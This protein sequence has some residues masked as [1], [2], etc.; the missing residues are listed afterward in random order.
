[1]ELRSSGS[2]L[3]AL[4]QKRYGALELWR[5]A[6]GVGTWRS[7]PQEVWRCVAGVLPPRG[8]ELQSSEV[9]CRRCLKRSMERWS[10]SVLLLLKFLA[11]VPHGSFVKPLAVCVTFPLNGENLANPLNLAG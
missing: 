3:Q 5:R 2:A 9:R 7:L 11:F 1:M 4:T 6:A 8:M 10:S